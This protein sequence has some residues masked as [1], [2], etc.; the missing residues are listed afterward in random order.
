MDLIWPFYVLNRFCAGVAHS[1]TG[2]AE[3]RDRLLL[4]DNLFIGAKSMIFNLQHKILLVTHT[5]THT[6]VFVVFLW[7][8]N[9]S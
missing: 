7:I 9:L 2:S 1:F 4:F 6:Y 5:H 3:D 8:I